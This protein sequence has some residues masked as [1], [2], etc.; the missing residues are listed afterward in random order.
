MQRSWSGQRRRSSGGR[1]W[2]SA[3]RG[4]GGEEGGDGKGEA[5][6]ERG[7]GRHARAAGESL[8]EPS[9]GWWRQQPAER[10]DT[11]RE[12]RHV[13][14][15]ISRRHKAAERMERARLRGQR[16]FGGM[17]T[18]MAA[19]AERADVG[20]A[21]QRALQRIRKRHIAAQRR[22]R[23]WER[24]QRAGRG[25][26]ARLVAGG[27][28]ESMRRATRTVLARLRERHRLRSAFGS[29]VRQLV[30]GA[31]AASAAAAVARQTR[32]RRAAEAWGDAQ[33]RGR[34][35]HTRA[36]RSTARRQT[37]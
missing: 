27:D 12:T 30:S 14:R 22:A 26:F 17:L 7:Q 24:S 21:T 2:R 18:R 31:E 23:G 13:L 33:G 37:Q 19:A 20:R 8:A 1:L 36:L 9:G 6:S 25:I 29:I 5:R 15:R 4:K 28:R 34:T 32:K 16:A 35:R 3:R 11:Q 10:A